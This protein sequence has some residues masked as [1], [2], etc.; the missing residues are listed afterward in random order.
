MS[1]RSRVDLPEPDGPTTASSDFSGTPKLTSSSRIFLAPLPCDLDRQVAGREGDLT[2]VDELLQ[3]VADQ[4]EDR[5][6][7]ADDVAGA[8]Q[9]RGIGWPLR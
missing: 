3:L 2:G 6:A 7:D 5:V 4:P 8:E 1:A 9:R